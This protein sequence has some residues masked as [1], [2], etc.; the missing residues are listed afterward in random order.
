MRND[1]AF[2]R[3]AARAGTCDV[4]ES[5][6]SESIDGTRVLVVEDDFDVAESLCAA[7]VAAGCE[8]VGPVSTAQEACDV[9]KAEPI[10]AAIL[11]IA[12]SPGTSAP[13]AR[14]L[15]SRGC[16]FV[17]VTGFSN[18]EMLPEDLRGHRV[19]LKPVDRETIR[20]TIQEL[21]RSATR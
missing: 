21:V 3:A 6:E 10:D 19:L 20:L 17:F 15:L 7:L 4:T 5:H 2:D 11:D 12:L 9:V 16:P 18:L 13:V 1:R 14:S 8:V